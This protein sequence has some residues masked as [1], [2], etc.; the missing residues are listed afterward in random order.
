MSGL[1]DLVV[2][3]TLLEKLKQALGKSGLHGGQ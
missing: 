2:A 1:V 3:G